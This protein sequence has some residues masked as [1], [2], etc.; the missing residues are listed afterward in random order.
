MQWSLQQLFPICLKPDCPKYNTRHMLSHQE[1]IATQI[2][3]GDENY[4]YWQGGVGSAKTLLWGA[5][6]AAYMIM[7]PRCSIILCRTDFSLLYSTLWLYF[8]ASIL[9]ATEQG[10]ITANYNKLW[11]RKTQG[12]YSICKLPNGSIARAV[13]LKNLRE[14]LGPNYDAIFISDA[15]EN[16][17]FGTI[18]HGE[19]TVGGLQSRLRGQASSFFKLS[20]GQYKDMRRFLVESNPPPN[21]NELHTIFGKGPGVRNLP[22]IDITYRHIQTSS[23]QN[24][25]N[26]ASYVAEIS[27]QHSD[28]NDI[29]RILEGKTIPYY[30]GVKVIPTFHSEV[31]VDK[32][33]VDKELP[34]FVGID[35]GYQHPAVIFTQIKRCSYDKEHVIRLSEISNLYNKTTEELATWSESDK[36]GILSHLGLFYPSHFDCKTY[37]EARRKLLESADDYGRIN[38]PVLE[39]YFSN[40]RFCIDRASEK[41][42]ASNKDRE[43]DRSILLLHYGIRAKYRTNIGLNRSLDRIREGFKQICLCNIPVHLI[44][45]NCLLLID[46]YSGG[47]RYAKLKD[48]THTDKPIEDHNYEDIADADRYLVENFYFISG[49]QAPEDEIVA[50]KD[51]SPW[52]WMERV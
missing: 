44:D 3:T 6:A 40:I 16:E 51:E 5:L 11:S 8:K 45:K 35:P 2:L 20:T 14:V 18:F 4:I 26:P 31:H 25:H 47:Y 12:D 22:G 19:G 42:Q 7:I 49:F 33:E 17:N 30:G 15:M 27:S 50:Y 24:D 13:Q 29:K 41:Q 32:F 34:L 48:G 46:A 39:Q 10:I 52:A 23:I 21:I 38:Y 28:P 37:T 43:T 1:E 9:A 36:L